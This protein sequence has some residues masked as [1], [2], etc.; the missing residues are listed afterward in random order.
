MGTQQ[1]CEAGL[2]FRGTS[3]LPPTSPRPRSSAAEVL[4]RD[5]TLLPNNPGKQNPKIPLT[6]TGAMPFARLSASCSAVGSLHNAEPSHCLPTPRSQPPPMWLRH[7]QWHKYW[8]QSV[9]TQGPLPTAPSPSGSSRLEKGRGLG[10]LPSFST[11]APRCTHP[12]LLSCSPLPAPNSTGY[13][14]SSRAK[15]WG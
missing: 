15:S 2:G 4:R 11:R 13:Q 10:F 5:R 9:R 3:S 14:V 6:G 7:P 8:S 1:P 12:S